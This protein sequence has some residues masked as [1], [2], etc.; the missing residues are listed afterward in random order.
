MLK[1][2]HAF[3]VV[4]M[5][6]A[7]PNLA[8]AQTS[9]R[10][11]FVQDSAAVHTA[12]HNGRAVGTDGY[13]QD[14][15]LVALQALGLGICLTVPYADLTGRVARHNVSVGQALYRPDNDVLGAAEQVGA[16]GHAAEHVSFLNIVGSDGAVGAAD[17]DDFAGLEGD[18][19]HLGLFRGRLDEDS[20]EAEVVVLDRVHDE[21]AINGAADQLVGALGVGSCRALLVKGG[22]LGG[23]APDVA[24]LAARVPL[25]LAGFEI[26]LG[27]GGGVADA[28]KPGLANQDAAVAEVLVRFVDPDQA[29]DAAILAAAD[30]ELLVPGAAGGVPDLNVTIGAAYSQTG[31]GGMLAVSG[32]G[33]RKGD[34]VDGGR[35]VRDESTAMDIHGC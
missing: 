30:D 35:L 10:A 1:R 4:F 33:M 34:G 17:D 26:P 14:I 8:P 11:L 9:A 12:T 24:V 18:A 6:T 31:D 22:G 3:D 27:N 2:S 23:D 19:D 29:V 21:L 28:E 20:L 25:G 13:A 7:S 5:I 15:L 16:E 32:P